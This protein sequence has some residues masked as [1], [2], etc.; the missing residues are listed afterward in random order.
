[1]ATPAISTTTAHGRTYRVYTSV[2]QDRPNTLVMELDAAGAARFVVHQI[3]MD[4][5]TA[6]KLIKG[7]L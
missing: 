3:D 4:H 7:E 1:M 5:E 6:I 2:I